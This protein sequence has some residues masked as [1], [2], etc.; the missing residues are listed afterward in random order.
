VPFLSK[1]LIEDATLPIRPGII[2]LQLTPNANCFW[3]SVVRDS[4]WNPTVLSP[5]RAV[6]WRVRFHRHTWLTTAHTPFNVLGDGFVDM[7]KQRKSECAKGESVLNYQP[8][9]QLVGDL[10][11]T[12]SP[13]FRFLLFT[14]CYNWTSRITGRQIVFRNLSWSY[15]WWIQDISHSRL[16]D[17]SSLWTRAGSTGRK[18]S[19]QISRFLREWNSSFTGPLL[20]TA[21]GPAVY[22]VLVHHENYHTS[23]FTIS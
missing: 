22:G 13:F 23:V 16:I 4:F 17:A 15:M 19:N 7:F 3:R 1:H 12:Q 6:V 18:N 8:K 5:E 10:F 21:V 2:T 14:S 9:S 11:F 20:A